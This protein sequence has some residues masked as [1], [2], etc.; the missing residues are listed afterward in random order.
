[1][2][3]PPT[4]KAAKIG[5][6]G[7]DGGEGQN[8]RYS[9]RPLVRH[10]SVKRPHFRRSASGYASAA[11]NRA[12]RI[13]RTDGAR[14]PNQRSGARGNREVLLRRLLSKQAGGRWY[15]LPSS[16]KIKVFLLSSA[17]RCEARP[18]SKRLTVG[19]CRNLRNN[20]EKMLRR[21]ALLSSVVASSVWADAASSRKTVWIK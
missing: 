6:G 10:P 5:G 20:D 12:A 13:I 3:L 18:E 4:A 19:R 21:N 7:F 1:M 17:A 9:I 2:A 16:G 15:E 14:G 11:Y 8:S